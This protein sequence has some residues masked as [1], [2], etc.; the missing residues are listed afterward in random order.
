MIVIQT[1]QKDDVFDLNEG[2]WDLVNDKHFGE[3]IRWNTTQFRFG[4]IEDGK[5]VGLIFGKH[6]SGTVFISN[7]IVFKGKRRQG[8]GTQLILKAEAFG[9]SYGDHKIWLISGAHYP[10][11]P[12]FENV[13]F[14]KEALL[15]NLYFNKDFIVY[16]KDIQ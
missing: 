6:E 13:G 15:P 4:A 8:I 16:T 12:F 3:G 10:E 1:V 14:K 9:K 11:D 7:I 5:V 2:E